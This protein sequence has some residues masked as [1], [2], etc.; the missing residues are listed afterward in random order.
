MPGNVNTRD[1]WE[2]RF[3]SGDWEA[4]Q[5]RRQ[6][7]NFAKGQIPHLQILRD[8]E[9]TIVDFGCG[10]GDAMPVY[11]KRFPRAKLV[12]V[13][14]SQ[15]AIDACRERYGAMASFLQGDCESIQDA[16]IVIASNVLEHLTND[17][18]VAKRLLSKCKSLYVTVPYKEWPL[19]S[20][21]V[22][23]YDEGYFSDIGGYVCRVFPCAGWPPHGRTGLAFHLYWWYQVS[24]KNI[25]RFLVRKPLCRRPMQI[26]FHFADS[27][28]GPTAGG[29]AAFQRRRRG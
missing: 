22:N 14:I 6:T 21:H 1:Y 12:G 27:S 15:N 26:L 17:R 4:K 11:R 23:T 2:H 18:E 13:D 16:D 5:G 25:L 20:E 19:C 9:G 24:F 10:L 29:S 28:Y 8:F 3:S 7:A